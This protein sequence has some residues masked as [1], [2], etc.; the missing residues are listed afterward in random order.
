MEELIHCSN[1]SQPR[2][3]ILAAVG[4]A[5]T[6][7]VGVDAPDAEIKNLLLELGE[8]MDVCRAYI[9]EHHKTEANISVLSQRYEGCREGVSREIDNEQL[10]N[11]PCD[12][13]EMERIVP[14][15]KSGQAVQGNVETFKNPERALLESQGIRSILWVPI[16]VSSKWWGFIGFDDCRKKRQWTE[17]SIDALRIAGGLIGASLQNSKTRKE[18]LRSET[19]FRNLFDNLPTVA[20]KSYTEKGV[21]QYWNKACET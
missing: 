1:R 4:N 9:F 8:A 14:L 18:L 20:V 17:S 15:F 6:K 3:Q 2:D 5:A 10:Q 13:T 21:I 12:S 19:R 7:L 11:I 16:V